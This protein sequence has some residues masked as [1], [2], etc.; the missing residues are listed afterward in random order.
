MSYGILY[1]MG[2]HGNIWEDVSEMNIAKFGY[3]LKRDI[4]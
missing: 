4:Y 2:R 3:G 1:N